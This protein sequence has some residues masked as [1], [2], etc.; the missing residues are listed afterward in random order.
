MN[1]EFLKI[2]IIVM[3]SLGACV[4]I[5]SYRPEMSFLLSVAVSVAVLTLIIS[6]VYPGIKT[7]EGIYYG[8]SGNKSSFGI[9]IKALIISYLAGFCGDTCRDFGQTALAQKVELAGRCAIFLLCVPLLVS[10]LKTAA[11]FISI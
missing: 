11:G 9:M 10:I 6:N 7:I 3:V 2:S 4:L 1:G 8:S 5:K